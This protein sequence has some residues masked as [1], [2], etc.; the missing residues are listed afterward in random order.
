MI[1]VNLKGGLGNQMFQYAAGWVLA[2]KNKTA[3]AVDL[4]FYSEFNSLCAKGY[5]PR[6]YSL[7]LFG[8]HPKRPSALSLALTRMSSKKYLIREKIAKSN[9][10][11][12]CLSKSEVS[13]LFDNNI[14]NI[15]SKHFYLDGYWQTE[16]YFKE[17]RDQII[18]L[19]NFKSTES[20]EINKTILEE[21][22]LHQSVCLHI[23][24][25]DF[26][27]NFEHDCVGISYYQ[28]AIEYFREVLKPSIKIFI[29]SDDIGWCKKNLDILDHEAIV[30]DDAYAGRDGF[31]HLY[32]MTQF[33]YFIISNST[34]A[35][36]GA[37]LSKDPFKIVIAPN[38]WSGNTPEQEIDI[39][40]SDWIRL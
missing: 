32:L 1:V 30:V 7:D 39:V 38:K 29:F 22:G 28:K 35:W 3:L 12:N 11:I 6:E 20:N 25:G 10:F 14:F 33:K 24:R 5:T 40:P 2:K 31:N 16:K 19:F 37:W 4:R 21:M 13:R 18:Q 15:R 17:F 9:K 8:I 36:W 34:F 23:R 27:G 26:I